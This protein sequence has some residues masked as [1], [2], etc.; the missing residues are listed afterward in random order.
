MFFTEQPKKKKKLNNSDAQPVVEQYT[1]ESFFD[2]YGVP[3]DFQGNFTFNDPVA[4][5]HA[6]L[7]QVFSFEEDDEQQ[8]NSNYLQSV[9]E[10]T[11]PVEP[12][13]WVTPQQGMEY[14]LDTPPPSFHPYQ[15]SPDAFE[16]HLES[17]YTHGPVTS[18]GGLNQGMPSSSSQFWE[19]T[20]NSSRYSMEAPP[21]TVTP[22]FFHTGFASSVSPEVSNTVRTGF[23][24]GVATWN[25]TP[26]PSWSP[27]QASPTPSPL[28]SA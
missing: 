17:T 11:A 27:A 16:T 21:S 26:S 3:V 10:G 14:R 12:P 8:R 15:P 25:G 13:F 1:T 20:S 19:N 9:V 6:D 22:S 7:D 4:E 24:L 5:Y 2:I 28:L 18:W 23:R